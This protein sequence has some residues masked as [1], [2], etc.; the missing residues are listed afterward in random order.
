VPSV[1]PESHTEP[2][3]V[4]L[5]TDAVPSAVSE[6]HTEPANVERE[7]D[8]VPSVVPE[9]HTEPASVASDATWPGASSYA[10]S[11]DD[12]LELEVSEDDI[13]VV[14]LALVEPN[15]DR[16]AARRPPPPPAASRA[17]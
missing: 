3:S 15:A 13:E 2:A 12:A 1:V 14:P 6:A 17:L 10:G 5:A 9:T 7:S 11:A 16:T 4:V 8:A